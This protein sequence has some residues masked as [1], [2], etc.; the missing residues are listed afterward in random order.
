MPIRTKYKLIIWA[1][2]SQR[3]TNGLT[4]NL[5]VDSLDGKSISKR[6]AKRLAKFTDLAT[7]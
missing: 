5:T 3:E 6:L 7:L 4:K 2:K 1:S